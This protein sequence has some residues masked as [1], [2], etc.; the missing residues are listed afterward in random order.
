M[1]N[2][3]WL[4]AQESATPGGSGTAVIPLFLLVLGAAA[5]AV[6]AKGVQWVGMIW[7]GFI[8]WIGFNNPI[9]A[10]TMQAIENVVTDLLAQAPSIP[11]LNG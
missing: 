6:K 7:G 4:F 5:Y 2:S 10:A 8:V 11:V 1:T 9:I 3:L